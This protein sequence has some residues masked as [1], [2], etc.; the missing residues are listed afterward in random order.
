MAIAEIAPNWTQALS[1]KESRSLSTPGTLDNG[2]NAAAAPPVASLK[3]RETSPSRAPI[4]IDVLYPAGP[5]KKSD[6]VRAITELAS[7]IEI[8]G[9][10]RRLA[11]T[12]PE[13]SDRL[14]IEAQMILPA[15]F[16]CRKGI[17]D[18]YAN[19][20]NSLHFGFANQRGTPLDSGQLTVVWRVLK[21][22]RN[23]PFVTFDQSFDYVSELE[24]AGLKVDPPKV[25]ILIDDEADDE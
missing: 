25:A 23:K 19:V 13:R 24:E 14:S 20:I 18:G 8:I 16:S 3:I 17:G 15:L 12:D 1:L 4:P 10:A 11:P 7:I 9:E 21:E 6:I 2:T 22:L 5:G